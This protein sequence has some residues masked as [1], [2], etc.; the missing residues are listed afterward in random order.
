MNIDSLTAAGLNLQA[1][2]NLDDLPPEMA[3]TLRASGKEKSYR[4][5][6][7][8]GHA[9]TAL[10]RAVK[11]AGMNSE[12]PIDDFTIKIF[13]Q[14][15]AE[16]M[17]GRDYQIV[18]P[19]DTPIGLQALGKLAGWHHDSPLMVGINDRWGTWFAYRA[20]V[21]A[22]S[23]FAPTQKMISHSPCPSCASRPCVSA[24]P[25]GALDGE[26]FSLPKCI[27]YRR[28]PS[29]PCQQTCLA[30]LACP[31]AS[32]H[33]YSSAQMRHTYSFSLR[34]ITGAG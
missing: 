25:A 27:D 20:A 30:R 8:L 7:L 26:E 33:R 13:G 4:Q 1:V 22:D 21:L 29:S 34:W 19:G 9:G 5:L 14:W 17:A 3:A 2:F 11:A 24:C 28:Q 6:I 18:Y 16:H 31:V 23:D 32:E 10:W 12:H 15:A